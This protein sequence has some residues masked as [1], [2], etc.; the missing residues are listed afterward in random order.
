MSAW[1]RG[2]AAALAGLGAAE[3]LG[4]AV[5]GPSLIDA[6]GK[7][8]VDTAPLPVVEQTVKYLR[9]ADKPVTRAAVVSAVVGA[10]ALLGQA[11]SRPIARGLVTGVAAAAAAGLALRPPGGDGARDARTTAAALSSAAAGA[12]VT[13]WALSVPTPRVRALALAGGA[14]LAASLRLR[15]L[16]I[17]RHAAARPALLPPVA[18]P[19]PPARDGAETWRDISPLLTPVEDF[20]VTDVT[21]RPPLIDTDGWHLDVSGACTAPYRLPYDQLLAGDLVEFDAVLSCVH[22]RLGWDRLGNQR[23]TGIPL[24]TLLDKAAPHPTARYVVTRAVDGWEC[25]LPLELLERTDAYV[26]V[27]IAGRPL[28]AAHGFPARVFVPGLYGQFTGAKWLTGLRLTEHPNPDYWLPRGWPRE[29][30]PVRPLARIDRPAPGRVPGPTV[31]CTGVAWAPPHGV[32]QVEVRVD[33][34]PWQTAELAAE[35]APAAWRRWRL[36]LSLT[37][38]EHTLQARCTSRDGTRQSPVPRTPFPTGTSGHHTVTITA[39]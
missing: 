9:A 31:T 25:S 10:G 7:L 6:A 11:R 17:R 34:G 14:G 37:P 1:L 12:A 33:G 15:G 3:L 28:T 21:M 22:N 18:S 5:R 30:V 29:P 36:P 4:A 27:G 26:V 24:R 8:V 35:L 23:W 19:L 2:G 32:T 13:A 20:Y 39:R 16:H 38:G